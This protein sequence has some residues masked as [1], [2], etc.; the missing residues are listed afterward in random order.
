MPTILGTAGYH[1]Y[2]Y[3]RENDEPPHIHV[4]WGNKLAK[5]WLD[6]VEL[7]SSRRFRAHELGPVR[8]LVQEHRE[9][10]PR[11]W[12]EHLDD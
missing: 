5:Y 6:P 4:E 2:F 8:Q 12:H 10:F 9:E 11:A 3:I 7:A 1:F